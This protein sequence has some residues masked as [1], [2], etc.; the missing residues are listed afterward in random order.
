MACPAINALRAPAAEGVITRQRTEKPLH[1]RGL[2]TARP[3][4]GRDRGA[5][6][7]VC[8]WPG[9]WNGSTGPSVPSASSRRSP[10]RA[11][12]GSTTW[13]SSD[14]RWR[15]MRS[16]YTSSRTESFRTWSRPSTRRSSSRR[17]TCSSRRSRP[18]CRRY[19]GRRLTHLRLSV[20]LF[21]IVVMVVL[22]VVIVRVS[23]VRV[24]VWRRRRGLLPRCDGRLVSR[25][26]RC[27]GGLHVY[28]HG[29]RRRRE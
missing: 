21:R 16:G 8:V 24:L 12:P 29:R 28:G 20:I 25:G 2:R 6:R 14:S 11:S 1:G 19:A 18:T 5:P 15:S 17:G 3:G 7:P 22:P 13:S 26:I 23:V 9:G 27:G 10:R 4:R